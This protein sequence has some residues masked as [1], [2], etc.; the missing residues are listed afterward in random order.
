MELKLSATLSLSL[1]CRKWSSCA[2]SVSRLTSSS[3]RSG[4]GTAL[5]LVELGAPALS[6][7]KVT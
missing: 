7:R 3:V 6:G 1:M 4:W 2:L 5:L